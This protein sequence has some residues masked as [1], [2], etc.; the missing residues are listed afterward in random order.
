MPNFA[1]VNAKVHLLVCDLAKTTTTYLEQ[2]KCE[3]AT[4]NAAIAEDAL[5]TGRI[6]QETHIADDGRRVQFLGEY[7]DMPFLIVQAGAELFKE[8]K[9]EGIQVG[10]GKN[11]FQRS[12]IDRRGPVM[13]AP[14][15]SASETASADS[16]QPIGKGIASKASQRRS[17][18]HGSHTEYSV[19]GSTSQD[20]G[21]VSAQAIHPLLARKTYAPEVIPKA[22]ALQISLSR[23]SFIKSA[24]PGNNRRQ[25]IKIDVFFNGELS[26]SRYVAARVKEEDLKSVIFA[27]SRVEIMVERAWIICPKTQ[28]PD[29]SLREGK[30]GTMQTANERWRDFGDALRKEADRYGVDRRGERAPLGQYLMALADMKMP[31]AVDGMQIKGGP[32]FGIVDVV[33][34]YGEG[35]K[36]HAGTEYLTIPSRM[37]DSHYRPPW[38]WDEQTLTE[39]EEAEEN[40]RAAVDEDTDG[41]VIMDEAGHSDGIR[42]QDFAAAGQTP[43]AESGSKAR[44]QSLRSQEHAKATP[45]VTATTTL[46]SGHG[47]PTP[48]EQPRT[49]SPD[50]VATPST[51]PTPADTAHSSSISRVV[52]SSNQRVFKDVAL[53]KPY[54]LKDAQSSNAATSSS[55]A[56]SGQP[57]SNSSR[58]RIPDRPN[59]DAGISSTPPTPA[60][61]S[62]VV[63]RSPSQRRQSAS[64]VTSSSPTRLT[65]TFKRGEKAKRRNSS[66]AASQAST[67]SSQAATPDS[68][69]VAAPITSPPG[70]MGPPP[71]R[72]IA[73][74]KSRARNRSNRNRN[75]KVSGGD[76]ETF[77]Y[78]EQVLAEHHPT[79]LCQDSAITYAEKVEQGDAVGVSGRLRRQS[80]GTGLEAKNKESL[81]SADGSMNN[82]GLTDGSAGVLR[83]I[84]SERQGVFSAE[85]ILFG[86]RFVVGTE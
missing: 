32:K 1:G 61:S 20:E 56:S 27:G 29:G 78:S 65:L 62:P 41:D 52:L 76:Y 51:L 55:A 34:S 28:N 59:F 6:L 64:N 80:S 33:L 30:K 12:H 26:H 21:S 63:Q 38:K 50:A 14:R 84:R 86:V 39:N 8:T 71:N 17:S 74:P 73:I 36:L 82:A 40:R 4:K 75:R 42:I 77:T 44:R 68:R 25:D 79:H 46:S 24:K 45:G 70:T 9:D 10:S 7:M 22:L 48:A 47:A 37:A 16:E 43:T 69:R 18:R 23:A 49:A 67:P 57:L 19:H 2:K 85:G 58:G 5:Q 3:N 60:E 54:H 81:A 53:S 66:Q 31:K 72:P 83:Q 13:S 15:M 11:V 35:K